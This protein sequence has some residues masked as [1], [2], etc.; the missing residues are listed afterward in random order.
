MGTQPVDYLTGVFVHGKVASNAGSLLAVAGP[1]R[2]RLLRPEKRPTYEAAIMKQTK[3]NALAEGTEYVAVGRP[4]IIGKTSFH[5]ARGVGTVVHGGLKVLKGLWRATKGLTKKKHSVP[6]RDSIRSIIIEEVER[7][8]TI[9]APELE[10]RLQHMAE[11]LRTLQQK[12]VELSSSGVS[13]QAAVSAAMAS[14][15]ETNSLGAEE[16]AILGRIFRQNILI[17][18]PDIVDAAAASA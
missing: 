18:K 9:P 14:V 7:L 5:L 8:G 3:E 2:I 1:V 11:M 16:K 13:R 17:Q 15:E 4:G 10:N 12:I 6:V